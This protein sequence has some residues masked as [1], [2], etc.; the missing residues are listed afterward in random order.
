MNDTERL[1]QDL[2]FAKAD[3][4]RLARERDDALAQAEV[5]QAQFDLAVKMF[6]R[7]TAVAQKLLD[8]YELAP[9]MPTPKQSQP[10]KPPPSKDD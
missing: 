4:L 8:G 7:L 6:E 9:I 1:L 3:N 2:D 10:G 5:L